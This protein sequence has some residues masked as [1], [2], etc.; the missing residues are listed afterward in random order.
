MS[1]S[2]EDHTLLQ[3]YF[4]TIIEG[5]DLLIEV[6]HLKIII[7]LLGFPTDRKILDILTECFTYY[8]QVWPGWSSSK[9]HT[10]QFDN[11]FKK[12]QHYIILKMNEILQDETIKNILLCDKACNINISGPAK[13]LDAIQATREKGM[14]LYMLF[15]F[16]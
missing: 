9:E 15:R 6:R 13:I 16:L 2:A 14:L 8:V 1:R 12:F 5:K 7:E 3:Q 4:K 10:S 11:C